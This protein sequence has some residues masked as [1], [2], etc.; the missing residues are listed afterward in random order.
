MRCVVMDCSGRDP[1][2]LFRVSDTLT[3]F[4]PPNIINTT[5]HVSCYSFYAMVNVLYYHQLTLK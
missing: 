2:G 4:I 5:A 1:L 3:G